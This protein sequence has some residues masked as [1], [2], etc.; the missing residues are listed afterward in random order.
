VEV[1]KAVPGDALSSE[2]VRARLFGPKIIHD[3]D[4]R[5]DMKAKVKS[6]WKFTLRVEDTQTVSMPP[7]SKIL[8]AQAQNENVCIW[9]LVDPNDP[10]RVD[11][12]IWVHG[13]GHPVED[14]AS[15]GRYVASVQLSG[16]ALVFHVFVGLGA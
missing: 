9:A 1:A 6:I 11:Y 8:T 12:P 7:D 3:F 2:W 13:T 4:R 16:G 15:Q 14:A 5:N 10:Q